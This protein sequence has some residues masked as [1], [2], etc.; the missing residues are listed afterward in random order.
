MLCRK[1]PQRKTLCERKDKLQ[2]QLSSLSFYDSIPLYDSIGHKGG[3]ARA[4]PV[5]SHRGGVARAPPVGGD[6]NGNGKASDSSQC[7]SGSK[8]MPWKSDGPYWTNLHADLVDSDH[9]SAVYAEIDRQSREVLSELG[10]P[11]TLR[12]DSPV[13]YSVSLD[14]HGEVSQN[15]I[16]T[17]VWSDVISVT[18]RH[19]IYINWCDTKWCKLLLWCHLWRNIYN[20][21]KARC[22]ISPL[23]L[24][25]YMINNCISSTAKSGKMTSKMYQLFT[26]H[27][28]DSAI[29]CLAYIIQLQ[30]HDYLESLIIFKGAVYILTMWVRIYGIIYNS[31]VISR[32]FA[33]RFIFDKLIGNKYV[34]K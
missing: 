32:I 31:N 15:Y 24:Y 21:T 12:G 1:T 14:T 33:A 19:D 7:L 3:V 6:R 9:D 2:Q 20:F 23:W 16:S 26:D 18:L 27:P 10:S 25:H 28:L 13:T 22:D 8:C 11:A 5:V 34:Q 4:P 30:L 17:H 29:L